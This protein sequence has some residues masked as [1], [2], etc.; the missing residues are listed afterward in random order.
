MMSMQGS[1]SDT[2]TLVPKVILLSLFFF[3]IYFEIRDYIA[4]FNEL[5]RLTE[6]DKLVRVKIIVTAVSRRKK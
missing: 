5:R 1:K 3:I 2:S 6:K 4:T